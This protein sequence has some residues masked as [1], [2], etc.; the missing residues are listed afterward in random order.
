MSV[1]PIIDS[2]VHLWDPQRVRIP[3]LDGVPPI[4]MR[5]DLTDYRAATAG[6]EIEGLVYLQV[7]VGPPYALIEARDL[8]ELAR[9]DPIV[10]AVVPWAPLEYGEKA[11]YFLE[12]MVALGPEIKGIRRIVQD[13]PD[14]EF[15]LH[16]DFVK[17]NQLLAEF[18]LTSDL[19]CNFRQFGSIVELVRQCPETQFI[20]DHIAKPNIRGGELEPW[21]SHM[22]D[23]ASLP[24]VVCKISGV[25]TEAHHDSWAIE[26]IK[27]YV[28]HALE[29]FGED[30]V[31]FGSD[32]P[33]ATLAVTYGRWV[34][35]LSDLTADWSD[36]ARSKLF[37]ENARRFYRIES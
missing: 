21:A 2:H 25:A 37:R 9:M 15:C 33:V 19:C 10:K 12:E 18:G 30:R 5:Y 13:E 17:G 14:P 31:V 20:L 35:T 16:P 23:L 27:P 1:G 24:N 6:L 29:S 4:N 11:R 8:V 28:L 22:R 26:D 7:E 36:S 34:E 32:W 3:W